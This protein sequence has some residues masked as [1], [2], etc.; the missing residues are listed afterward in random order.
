M[1]SDAG[2][3]AAPFADRLYEAVR[4][5]GSRVCVGLDPVLERLP[6]E[7]RLEALARHG[8]TALAVAVAYLEFCKGI[9]DA[10]CDYAAVVKPQAAFFEACGPAGLHVLESVIGHAHQRGLL[11]IEDAKRGDIG[12]TAEAYASGH[13]GQLRLIGG[14]RAPAFSPDALTVNPYL[15]RDGIL[16]F[17]SASA[18]HGKGIFVLVRTSN[19]SAGDLQDLD[20]GGTPVYLRVARLLAEL[21][22]GLKGRHGYGPVGAVVGATYPEQA[23]KIR[24]VLPDSWFLVPGFGAQGATAADVRAAFAP[25]GYG[26]VVSSSRGVIFAHQAPWA[27]QAKLDYKAAAGEAARRMRDEINSAL[28]LTPRTPGA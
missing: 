21:G 13:L 8:D 3:P 1:P 9:I 15:G 22:G 17:I 28:G 12:N 6:E 27:I 5:K 25:D 23:S 18:E 4:D 2:T 10:T 19:P 7:I 11:V 26:A 20:A 24:E 16:P 14:G